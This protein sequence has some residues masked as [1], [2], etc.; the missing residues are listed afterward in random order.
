MH[1]QELGPFSFDT[2]TE[3]SR[4]TVVVFIGEARDAGAPP[5]IVATREDRSAD[6]DLSA[7]A[8]RKVFGLAKT[9]PGFELLGSRESKVD[10]ESAFRVFIRWS[11]DRGPVTQGFA[12]VDGDD[13]T[14][15]A[16]TCSAI[17]QADTFDEFERVLA[18]V[19]LDGARGAHDRA[20][21]SMVVPT[22]PP[23]SEAPPTY[24]S[25]PMPGAR[26]ARR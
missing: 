19:H 24:E 15:L 22:I 20:R 5:N 2:P 17:D 4:R 10:G 25:I 9:L 3:W 14:A 16:I 7:H 13:G 11:S 26:P 6:E 21:D 23:A 1:S 12:W 8:W 18:S